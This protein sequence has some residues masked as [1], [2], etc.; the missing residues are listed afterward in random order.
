MLKH[1][2]LSLSHADQTVSQYISFW[3]R[4]CLG[5]M[6]YNCNFMAFIRRPRDFLF[7]INSRGKRTPHSVIRHCSCALSVNNG[8]CGCFRLPTMEKEKTQPWIQ[9]CWRGSYH[10]FS[11]S[12][13]SRNGEL[14]TVLK[15]QWTELRDLLMNCTLTIRLQNIL[16]F[17][18]VLL[19]RKQEYRMKVLPLIHFE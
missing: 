6:Y 5:E 8:D 9:P 17:H 10:E 2:V 1:M 13:T 3:G 11:H 14:V 4:I 16:Y 12:T 18:F 7:R 19:F 15:P